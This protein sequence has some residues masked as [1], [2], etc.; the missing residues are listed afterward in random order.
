MIQ[1]GTGK[2]KNRSQAFRLSYW[3][4]EGSLSWMM[5]KPVGRKGDH[6]LPALSLCGSSG[7][8]EQRTVLLVASMAEEGRNHKPGKN[9][10]LTRSV[11]SFSE[12]TLKH[13]T[14]FV[15]FSF[16]L[17]AV[18]LLQRFSPCDGGRWLQLSLKFSSLTI[19]F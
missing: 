6:S 19:A 14:V 2:K 8:C 4:R 11:T 10:S 5:D 15:L 12:Q 16:S 9:T 18:N 3:W 1:Y 13:F 7:S 17:G